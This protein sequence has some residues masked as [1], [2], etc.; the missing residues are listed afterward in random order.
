MVEFALGKI[1]GLFLFIIGLG[2]LKEAQWIVEAYHHVCKSP[3]AQLITGFIPVLL[4]SILV[5]THSVWIF[6]WPV[7]ITLVGYV[8]FIIG[9]LRYLFIRRWL[10][11]VKPYVN[12]KNARLMGVFFVI[13]GLILL[14]FSFLPLLAIFS[15]S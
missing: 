6:A 13:Y 9:S 12:P 3:A 8:V 1:I 14:Y 15:I 2:M 10:A 11:C 7:M 5:I 4:G